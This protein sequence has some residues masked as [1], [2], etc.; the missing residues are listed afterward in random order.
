[1]IMNPGYEEG[2]LQRYEVDSV[3][4]GQDD[5]A[6]RPSN[7]LYTMISNQLLT[8]HISDDVEK[9]RYDGYFNSRVERR[10]KSNLPKAK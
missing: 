5:G 4:S 9:L 6:D 1:M 7:L 8:Y 2:N 10:L 3:S